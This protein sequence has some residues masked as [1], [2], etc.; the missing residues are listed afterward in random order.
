MVCCRAKHCNTTY[1]HIPDVWE[2]WALSSV[3]QPPSVNSLFVGACTSFTQPFWTELLCVDDTDVLGLGDN[4]LFDC[5]LF[6]KGR[7]VLAFSLPLRLFPVPFLAVF[8]EAGSEK[9]PSKLFVLSWMVGEDFF[10]FTPQVS[11]EFDVEGPVSES[12]VIEVS[13]EVGLIDWMV[14]VDDEGSVKESDWWMGCDDEVAMVI[15][16]VSNGVI[17]PVWMSLS[18]SERVSPS[19]EWQREL[20][21]PGGSGETSFPESFLRRDCSRAC[22]EAIC[23]LYM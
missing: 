11:V 12:N 7:E 1:A 20:A 8:A 3:K 2:Q 23:F 14:E 17:C 10:G 9:R 19:E 4:F 16:C 6:D 22:N 5:L 15:E 21:T 13:L 18:L